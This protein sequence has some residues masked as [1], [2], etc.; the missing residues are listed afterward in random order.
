LNSQPLMNQ[1]Y[2]IALQMPDMEDYYR[3]QIS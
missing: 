2:R 3:L 1:P